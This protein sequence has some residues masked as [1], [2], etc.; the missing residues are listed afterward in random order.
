MNLKGNFKS[1]FQKI[2]ENFEYTEEEKEELEGK[3][4]ISIKKEI[5]LLDAFSYKYLWRD[6]CIYI[7]NKFFSVKPE[8]III[9]NK[10][11]VFYQEDNER[12]Y[13]GK[14]EDTI[15]Y[16]N[17]IEDKYEKINIDNFC[18][19]TEFFIKGVKITQ[20]L[21]EKL[22]NKFFLNVMNMKKGV[23]TNG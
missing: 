4:Y 8:K 22:D 17:N 11:D 3:E 9:D 1:V 12:L 20:F 5:N 18:N 19:S 13:V 2:I 23:N 6:L 15:Y 16:F 7:D 10:G 21:K 14:I